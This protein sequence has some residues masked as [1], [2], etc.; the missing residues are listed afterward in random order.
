MLQFFLILFSLIIWVSIFTY[1]WRAELFRWLD[2]RFGKDTALKY[3]DDED[4]G[5]TD[6]A[7]ELFA[8]PKKPFAPPKKPKEDTAKQDDTAARKNSTPQ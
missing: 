1:F 3:P 7:A 8:P 2:N 4:E 5:T 6:H